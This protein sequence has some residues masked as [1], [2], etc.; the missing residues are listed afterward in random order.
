MKK[1][2]TLLFIII[3]ILVGASIKSEYQN[4]TISNNIPEAVFNTNLKLNSVPNIVHDGI[5]TPDEYEYSFV[6]HTSPNYIVYY[7]INRSVMYMA[8]EVEAKGW[9]RVGFGYYTDGDDADIIAGYYDDSDGTTHIQDSYADGNGNHEPDT[10]D[11][12]LSYAGSENASSTI[13]EFS[14]KLET[15]DYPDDYEIVPGLV[16][17]VSWAFHDTAD[18]FTTPQ[19]W[20]NEGSVRISFNGEPSAPYDTFAVTEVDKVGLYWTKSKGD[21]D[22]TTY[23][24]SSI[25]QYNIYR[26]RNGGDYQ[27]IDNVGTTPY[28]STSLLSYTDTNVISSDDYSYAVTAVT[29]AGESGFSNYAD[30]SPIGESDVVNRISHEGVISPGEY[31][32]YYVLQSSPLYIMRYTIDKSIIY[33]ALEAEV[34][35]WMR[36]G[37]GYYTSGNDADIMVGYYNDTDGT[38]HVQDSYADGNGNHEPD[39]NDNVL[40]YA[41]SE[42]TTKTILEFSRSLNTGDKLDTG[43]TYSNYPDDYEIIPG[44]YLGISWAFHDTADDFTTPQNW[45]NSGSI[46]AA[47]DGDPG[48]PYDA[49]A[50]PYIGQ[51]DLMWN[52]PKGDGN[53]TTYGTSSITHYNI[54]RSHEGGAYQFIGNL[55]LA[56]YTGSQTLLSYTDDN[57]INDDTYSYVI[58]SVTSHGESGFSNTVNTIPL[59][60]A[61]AANYTSDGVISPG[62]YKYF[63]IIQTNPE[64]II[65]YTINQ[66]TIYVGIEAEA[67]GWVS[68]G[69][70]YF[71]DMGGSDIIIGY[72]DGTSHIAD[73]HA[74]TSIAHIPDE[75]NNL[76]SGYVGETNTTTTME[77]SRLLDT[78]DSLDDFV[79]VPNLTFKAIWGA[80]ST[81]DDFYSYHDQ[82]NLYGSTPLTF[83]GPP[84]APYNFYSTVEE[85]QVDLHWD[86]PRGTKGYPTSSYNIYR[87]L[88]GGDFQ[89]I[90]NIPYSYS[91]QSYTDMSVITGETYSYYMTAINEDGESGVSETIT[92]IPIG[93]LT[94]PRNVIILPSAGQVELAW[95]APLNDGGLPVEEYII[96][97]SDSYD[98]VYTY[99]G[100]NTSAL[101]FTDNSIVNGLTYYYMIRASHRILIGMAS[102]LVSARPIGEPSPPLDVIT[103]SGD[104]SVIINWT[105]P[106]SD[107]GF[108]IISYTIY[109]SEI[110][111]GPY[112]PIGTNTSTLGYLDET[113]ENAKTYYYV[114]T[115][116]NSFGESVY[117]GEQKTTLANVPYNPTNLTVINGNGRVYLEWAEA[118]GRGY[119][120]SNYTIYRLSKIGGKY[121]YIGSTTLTYYTDYTTINGETYYYVITASNSFGESSY[122]FQVTGLPGFTPSIPLDFAGRSTNS[123]IKLVWD[124]PDDN[125]GY[126]IS[127][128][129]IYRSTTFDGE[130][131]KIGIS[132]SRE[133][134]DEDVTLG[135]TYYYIISGVNTLGEGIFSEAI[136][137]V[138]STTPD[139]PD[140]LIAISIDEG[141]E[142]RWDV[143]YDG[144][145]E[146]TL[147]HIYRSKLSGEPY[148]LVGTTL[149][150]S[151]IDT[152]SNSGQIY[153]YVLTALN[154]QG[155]SE[156]SVEV[157]IIPS[158]LPSAPENL[159][160]FAANNQVLLSWGLSKYD[161]GSIITTYNIYR[162]TTIDSN[163]TLIDSTFDIAYT[164][165]TVK[166]YKTYYFV[167]TAQNAEGESAYSNSIRVT[168]VET[169]ISFDF[170]NSDLA[171]LTDL[172]NTK[173]NQFKLDQIAFTSLGVITLSIFVGIFQLRRQK[174]K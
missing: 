88:N 166:N 65:Y 79:I 131:E 83:F 21:G 152:T 167:I 74:I 174:L 2:S 149:T 46:R 8:L 153:Y 25:T 61:T 150:N 128:Y 12:V 20:Q 44:V 53:G 136:T 62:E 172:N 64:F 125:G 116:S 129:N 67:L 70:D 108:S 162:S 11:N 147:Y 47:L 159:I 105:T 90:D 96:Y 148:N 133:F 101:G 75:I 33:V 82:S 76:L 86:K 169:D 154:L 1:Q 124:Q 163:Y 54:Y 42:T 24:T 107:G 168:P 170:V 142:L 22:D 145:E 14:R 81:A 157:S 71:M 112:T 37:F 52:R 63:I 161:G 30:V 119:D 113:A 137:V 111:G 109:R 73:N 55:S 140:N 78:G 31:E 117:S 66:S 60:E 68:I 91:L 164:D 38:T 41:G 36:I 95:D 143:P 29:L 15:G 57:I 13:L 141:I 39:T 130:Y 126:F 58:T 102:E 5:I 45:Q 40:S 158:G 98:G 155:E 156:Y 34:K 151:F 50:I 139:T 146:I 84:E 114:I 28:Y 7:T 69:L 89:L 27:L 4:D 72:N 16:R 115:V 123:I 56:D 103:I 93:E 144:G 92:M 23:G 17:A 18:D 87:S 99:I 6:L 85:D 80:H 32:F 122:S 165:D 110:Q 35:G 10:I 26:S 94:A 48:A 77:F 120:I 51:V 100:T 59:S 173:P 132:Y 43:G 97:R 160:G 134:F 49:F 3:L 19:N 138:A 106:F 135:I 118:D 171:D 9:I 121:T 127:Y 104:N